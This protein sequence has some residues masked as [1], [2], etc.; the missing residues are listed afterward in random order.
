[1]DLAG[2]GII[3]MDVHTHIEGD[4]DLLFP[5]MSDSWRRRFAHH[6]GQPLPDP[7]LARAPGGWNRVEHFANE[8]AASGPNRMTTVPPGGGTPGSDPH[9]IVEDLFNQHGIVAG[10]MT[11]MQAGSLDSWED[12]DEA[13]VLAAAY[14]DYHQEHWLTVDER[15]KLAMGVAPHDPVKAA[16]EI[17]R[18]GPNPGVVATWLPLVDKLLGSPYYDPILAAA[19][20]TGIAVASHGNG[21]HHNIVGAPTFPGGA[22]SFFAQRNSTLFTLAMAHAASLV[23]SGAFERYP[24]LKVIFIEYGWAWLP[25]LMWTMDAAWHAAGEDV[26]NVKKP[27]SEY[28]I[29]HFRLTSQ[30]GCDT[31][32]TDEE[33]LIL[34]AM[35]AERTLLF[36]TDYPHWDGDDPQHVFRRSSDELQRRIFREN[37]L[38]TI[39]PK[40]LVP[41]PTLATN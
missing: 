31:P 39:G 20:E 28:I 7:W 41:Q 8:P 34:E 26:P 25:S 32:S 29:E 40:L 17:R 35:H 33:N 21:N 22:P 3:D 18:T 9:F 19:A 12:G 1:M 6:E 36:A 14:N 15:F 23:W 11:N 10:L 27:P 24:T 5:Y 38:E 13:A 37:A 30:P 4:F 16:A 2:L